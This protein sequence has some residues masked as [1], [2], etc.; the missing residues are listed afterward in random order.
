ME[1]L[2]R[3]KQNLIVFTLNC[4]VM[5]QEHLCDVW[6]VYTQNSTNVSMSRIIVGIGVSTPPQKHH[7]PLSCQDPHP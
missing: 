5:Y 4:I 1:I 2:A 7:S 3:M 6:L